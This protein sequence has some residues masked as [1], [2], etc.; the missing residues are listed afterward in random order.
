MLD[1]EGSVLIQRLR[2]N[3]RYFRTILTNAGFEIM[4]HED[5]PIAPIW[6]GDTT[7]TRTF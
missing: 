1:E 6:L 2:E 7:L 5:S 4:G 3:S